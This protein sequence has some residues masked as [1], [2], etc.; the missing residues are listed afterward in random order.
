MAKP[1]T[2]VVVEDTVL[3]MNMRS[4]SPIF[5][6]VKTC[7]HIAAFG[8]VWRRYGIPTFID[9]GWTNSKKIDFQD[10][11]EKSLTALVAALSGCNVDILHGGVYGELAFHPLQAILD[12]DVA[13][14][15]GKFIEGVTVNEKT[16]AT[17]LIEEIGPIPG[18]F[19]NTAHTRE[20]FDKETYFPKAADMLAYQEWEN[21]GR[22]GALEL[23]RDR[24][25]EILKTHEPAPLP[26]DQGREI[27]KILGK[28]RTFYAGK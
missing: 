14:M 6:S 5:G 17:G 10:G 1:G 25:E 24:M 11:Y 23:A 15:I 12:D 28:A 26:E 16:L 4:G 2:R 18:H 22:R 3:P 27:E 20:F 9:A 13:G 7:L 8:Q 19:L 21:G